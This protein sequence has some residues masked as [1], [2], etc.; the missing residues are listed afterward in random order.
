MLTRKT[1]F[2]ALAFVLAILCG[3]A[4]DEDELP[5]AGPPVKAH[6]YYVEEAITFSNG[7][8][9]FSTMKYADVYFWRD[10]GPVK[11]PCR[12]DMDRCWGFDP[13][14]P[15]DAGD[16]KLL[17]AYIFKP[18]TS[19]ATLGPRQTIRTEGYVVSDCSGKTASATRH[20]SF[21]AD[22]TRLPGPPSTTDM[23]NI[24]L[25]HGCDPA[26]DTDLPVPEGWADQFVNQKVIMVEKKKHLT[27]PTEYAGDTVLVV[28]PNDP[29]LA[30]LKAEA[31]GRMNLRIRLECAAEGA[32]FY[33]IGHNNPGTIN[34]IIARNLN[35]GFYIQRLESGQE[36]PP[37][38]ARTLCPADLASS[39]FL[40]TENVPFD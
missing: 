1:P 11:T 20:L 31:T 28:N 35:G 22:L 14:V 30:G 17:D 27:S 39:V 3:C 32:D 16:G 33:E 34:V 4:D 18:R 29:A 5:P 10:N 13:H 21:T 6:Q 15:L 19:F 23:Q 26:A 9:T 7:I 38:I 37:H 2:L 25:I 12:T 40:A 8:R 24:A 36:V